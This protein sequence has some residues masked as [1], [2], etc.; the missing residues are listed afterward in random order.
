MF[1]RCFY[2]EELK[3]EEKLLKRYEEELDPFSNKPLTLPAI[4]CDMYIKDLRNK[5]E[6]IDQAIELTRRDLLKLSEELAR[7]MSI[8]IVMRKKIEEKLYGEI[9]LSNKDLFDISLDGESDDLKEKYQT[10]REKNPNYPTRLPNDSTDILVGL[11]IRNFNN[12]YK[13]ENHVST[14]GSRT[15][16]I[17]AILFFLSVLFIYPGILKLIYIAVSITATL[18]LL[19]Q[20][21][22]SVIHKIMI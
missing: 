2:L 1:N 9:F 22:K 6:K 21:G 16:I 11:S 18:F 17:L 12:I 8:N 5:L 3:K 20:I 4:L 10:N 14:V 7:K 19:Y 13:V 15:W